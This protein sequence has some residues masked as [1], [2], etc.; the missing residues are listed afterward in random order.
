MNETQNT[1]QSPYDTLFLS[2]PQMAHF[3]MVELL[4]YLG[5]TLTNQNHIR[6]E[7]SL[8]E[9]DIFFKF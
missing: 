6:E 7:I 2:V 4:K 8:F 3:Q 5:K 9:T 1:V